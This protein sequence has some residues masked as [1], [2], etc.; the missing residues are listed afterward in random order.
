MSLSNKS[1]L[2]TGGIRGIGAAICEIFLENDLKNL[3]VLDLNFEDL[4]ILKDWE[5]KFPQASIKF[6]QVDVS[7]HEELE[8][9]YGDFTQSIESLD[10]GLDKGLEQGLDIVVNCAGIFNESKFRQVIDVNLSG[11]IGSTLLAIEHMR[12]DKGKG[13]GG[14]VVNIASI[15]G[16]NPVSFMPTYSATKSGIITFTNC[17]AHNRDR[18]GIK[19]LTICPSFTDTKLTSENPRN[20][21]YFEVD[22]KCI[23]EFKKSGKFQSPDELAKAFFP[24]LE[25]GKSGSVWIIEGGELIEATGPKVLY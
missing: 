12:L 7:N 24:V 1:A 8:K 25:K 11:V 23:T 22:E 10:P 13:R 4:S 19:F 15:G 20:V 17:V 18:L 3:A 21:A 2:V 14:V 16:L 5:K 6:Y 9:C